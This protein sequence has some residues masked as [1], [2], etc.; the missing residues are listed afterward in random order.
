MNITEF[1]TVGPKRRELIAVTIC[2][3]Q[4]HGF[5]DDETAFEMMAQ[6]FEAC[7]ARQW[8]IDPETFSVAS[9]FVDAQLDRDEWVF[10]IKKTGDQLQSN[11]LFKPRAKE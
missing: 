9:A 7:L 1:Q 2:L 4:L 6:L 5:I 10:T 3:A 11:I 8:G